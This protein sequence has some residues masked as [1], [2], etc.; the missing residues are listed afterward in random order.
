MPSPGAGSNPR[1]PS[2]PR[3][4][5]HGG[6]DRIRAHG[7]AGPAPTAIMGGVS[8]GPPAVTVHPVIFMPGASCGARRGSGSAA[9]VSGPPPTEGPGEARPGQGAVHPGRGQGAARMAFGSPPMEM[10][11]R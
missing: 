4:N 6:M 10:M 11:G 5:D 1:G 2:G 3:G 7:A 9:C 8:L